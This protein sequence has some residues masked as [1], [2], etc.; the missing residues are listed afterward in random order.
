MAVDRVGWSTYRTDRPSRRKNN[1]TY[2]AQAYWFRIAVPALATLTEDTL[3][4]RKG[5]ELHPEWTRRI[6]KSM[7]KKSLFQLSE[8]LLHLLVFR[9]TKNDQVHITPP[10]H[11]TLIIKISV[12]S[13]I[14]LNRSHMPRFLEIKSVHVIR[15]HI[16][17]SRRSFREMRM[18]RSGRVSAC[19][20]EGHQPME[21]RSGQ[22]VESQLAPF[23]WWTG[24]GEIMLQSCMAETS[25]L[26][27]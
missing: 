3:V 18:A 10:E 11:T 7:S 6:S 19:L 9:S 20:V 1:P 14:T 16:W 22:S 25:S 23:Y 24:G 26:H 5:M 2:V 17:L 8:L 4:A 12:W 27:L 21:I 15:K 13:I